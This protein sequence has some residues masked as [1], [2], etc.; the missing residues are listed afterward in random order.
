MRMDTGR[1]ISKGYAAGRRRFIRDETRDGKMC[2]LV[3]GQ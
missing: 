1:L 2:H 3:R